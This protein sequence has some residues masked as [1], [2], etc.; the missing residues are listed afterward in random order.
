MDEK[1]SPSGTLV[2]PLNR[3]ER[4]ILL[5][6]AEDKSNR[7]IAAL[8]VLAVNSVKWYIQQIF[9]KLGVNKRSEAIER[10]RSLGLLAALGSISVPGPATA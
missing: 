4:A 9:G 3:R 2:E 1:N 5:H 10:A 6:L 8:E 7:E